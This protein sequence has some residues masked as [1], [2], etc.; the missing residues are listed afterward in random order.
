MISVHTKMVLSGVIIFL[1]TMIIWCDLVLF[2]T[3]LKVNNLES[4]E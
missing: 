1:D 4:P 3:Y 2:V